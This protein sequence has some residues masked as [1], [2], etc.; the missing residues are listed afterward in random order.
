MNQGVQRSGAAEVIKW[1]LRDGRH[2]THMREFGDE[3]CRRIVAAGI[4]IW[5]GFCSVSTLHPQVVASAYI[6]RREESGA[7]RRTAPH[8]FRDSEEWAT[9]PISEVRRTRTSVRRRLSDP[10]CA[11]DFPVVGELRSEGGTDYVAIPLI[12]SSGDINVISFASNHAGGFS[13]DDLA[14][15]AA[16]AEALA[17]IVELQ[18]TRRVARHLLDTYVGHRTGEKVLSGAITRGSCETISAVIWYCDLRGF[19]RLTDSL[20]RNRVIDLLNEY[21]EIVVDAVAAEGGEA[22][23]FVGD[24]LLAIFELDGHVAVSDRC[25]AALRAAQ[26]VKDKIEARN[27]QR[28]EAGEP[29]IHFGLALH[30]GEVSYGNIGAPNRLDFTVVGP[31]VNHAARLQK[32]AGDLGREVVT[33]ASFA[34]AA[35]VTME[36]LG[37]YSLRGVLEAQELF[38]PVNSEP[39]K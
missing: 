11:M 17:I 14:D 37:R 32:L 22:L 1:M 23:K 30:L 15:L 25:Q 6:W 28:R 36:P 20:A 26:V 8:A 13:D 19:T 3:M 39:R 4:P 5:R 24:A 2:I 27:H 31:A 18:S 34:G 16:V 33:S 10:A 12:C 9:S 7:V 21:F 35:G 38:A 29:E